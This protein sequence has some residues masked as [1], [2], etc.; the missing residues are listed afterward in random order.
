MTLAEPLAV[1]LTVTAV[2]DTLG[3]EYAVGGS[4]ASSMH[5][6]PRSTNDADLLVALPGR[7]I[8]DFVRALEGEFYVDRD[9]IRDAVRQSSSFNIIHLRTMFKVDIF[10][11]DRSGLIREELAR[12]EPA[13]LGDPP[14]VLQVCSAEDII[15]QKLLWL[16]SGRET[17]DRQW[18]DLLGVIQIQGDKLD[19]GYLRRWVVH[20]DLEELARRAFSQAGQSFPCV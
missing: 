18:G 12:R 16:R 13:V 6:I 3:L 10:V 11:A 17:S 2:L 5:G 9:M 20:L 8:D 1:T 7:A 14:R 15:L 4:L 19:R